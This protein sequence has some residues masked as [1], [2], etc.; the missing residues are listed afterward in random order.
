MNYVIDGGDNND[1]T[2]GGALQLFP[3]EAIEEFNVMTHR[4]DAEHGRGGAVLNVVTKSGT[5]DLRGSWFSLFRDDG[6]NAQT[7]TERSND[8]R[9]GLQA[10][11]VRRQRWRASSWTGCTISAPTSALNRT[12]SRL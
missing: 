10:P 1:D 7:F 9:A 11:S 4:F 2:V 12:P 6:L 8:I 3:L 5:N